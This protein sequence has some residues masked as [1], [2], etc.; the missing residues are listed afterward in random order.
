LTL[1]IIMPW[2]G[3]CCTWS[4]CRT[5][6]WVVK[7]SKHIHTTYFFNW[8]Y[9]GVC[10]CRLFVYRWVHKYL[11]TSVTPWYPDGVILGITV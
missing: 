3:T 7:P 5:W 8:F 2:S 4:Y 6:Y 1:T 10:H 11:R 9:Y